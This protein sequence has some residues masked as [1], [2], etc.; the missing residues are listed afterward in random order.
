MKKI[1][2]ALG[3]FVFCLGVN[4]NAYNYNQ[5]L[6]E[7]NGGIIGSLNNCGVNFSGHPKYIRGAGSVSLQAPGTNFE[8]IT[9]LG[10]GLVTTI[11]ADDLSH[12]KMY[13]SPNGLDLSGGGDTIYLG[14][15]YTPKKQNPIEIKDENKVLLLTYIPEK[16][17]GQSG[18][19]I[20]ARAELRTIDSSGIEKD[21]IYTDTRF[22]GYASGKIYRQ[23][24]NGDIFTYTSISDLLINNYTGNIESS[25][26][27]IT[28]IKAYNNASLTLADGNLYYSK[29]ADKLLAG[30]LVENIYPTRNGS[31]S[32]M[33]VISD[34]KEFIPILSSDI[35]I[36]VPVQK[37]YIILAH[38]DGKISR[39]GETIIQPVN[40]QEL[41]SHLAQSLGL[42]HDANIVKSTILNYGESKKFGSGY[43]VGVGAEDKTM[44][45]AVG[46]NGLPATVKIQDKGWSN[47]EYR[48]R[49]K[50]ERKGAFNHEYS[51]DILG[52]NEMKVIANH[53]CTALVTV[54]NT[55]L[56]P[57]EFNTSI[58][59]GFGNVSG[60]N[61]FSPIP[62]IAL[63][64]NTGWNVLDWY[65][66]ACD[67]IDKTGI[68]GVDLE[69]Y[70]C[71]V[72][73]ET[74]RPTVFDPKGGTQFRIENE[75]LIWMR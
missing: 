56:T 27:K 15:V 48:W 2:L 31:I 16:I 54:T 19:V 24:D 22:I 3:L 41:K 74:W 42:P 71:S 68:P 66:K 52:E 35:T 10:T 65:L 33:E 34:E 64:I 1:K 18:H 39:N 9:A 69:D 75:R 73:P 50:G 53:S 55:S 8:T 5:I 13:Y 40:I 23:N 36:F 14:I 59:A 67:W 6:T 63:G 32:N 26:K 51:G 49:N 43:F 30:P 28:S 57:I 60:H 70:G 29:S 17:V 61:D 45:I 11:R 58:D 46:L 47:F 7:Y 38:N 37:Q 62:G 25:T 12:F 21:Y 44:A 20:P 4:V 72:Y